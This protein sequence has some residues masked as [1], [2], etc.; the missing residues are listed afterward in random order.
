MSPCSKKVS[1]EGSS[2][3]KISSQKK[4]SEA[5]SV[6]MG[7]KGQ[8]DNTTSLC[9]DRYRWMYCLVYLLYTSL[10]IYKLEC[11]PKSRGH[12]LLPARSLLERDTAVEQGIPKFPATF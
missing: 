3:L 5:K 4:L 11:P 2:E 12:F 9:C 8:A 10:V 7:N 1:N 6:Y